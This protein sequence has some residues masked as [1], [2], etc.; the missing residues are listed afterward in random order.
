MG[1][2]SVRRSSAETWCG[3]RWRNAA[4][5][6]RR[7]A[8]R[9]GRIQLYGACSSLPK[10]AASWQRARH[11]RVW[12]LK[13]IRW[14]RPAKWRRMLFAPIWK[15][16][17]RTICRF[18]R[19]D[20]RSKKRY[21][22]CCQNRH[23]PAPSRAQ[24]KDVLRGLTRAGFFIHHTAG[25]HH[26][27]KHPDRPGLRVTLAWAQQGP[28]ATDTQ[29]DHRAERLHGRGVSRP[30]LRPNSPDPPDTR[31]AGSAPSR[32]ASPSSTSP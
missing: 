20:R 1:G 30:A 9:D 31:P 3:K 13:A 16:C 18:P 4:A 10:R 15:A 17:T 6:H 11:C 14:R 19:I 2:R 29:I 23:E 28:E 21:A 22:S 5:Y 32:S 25:S 27:L 26:V 24:T 8:D 7:E 12:S